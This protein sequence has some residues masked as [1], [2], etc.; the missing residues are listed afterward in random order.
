MKSKLDEMQEKKLAE[1][2]SSAYWIAF[3]GLFAA[4]MIQNFMGN[5]K[6]ALG[7][8][9]VFLVLALYVSVRCIRNGI[10]DRR[11]QANRRTNLIISLI[12]G[13]FVFAFNMLLTMKWHNTAVMLISSVIT[14]VFTFIICFAFLSICMTVYNKRKRELEGEEDET[15]EQ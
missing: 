3:W 13:A 12:G 2:E 6:D 5:V 14:A 15:E 8:L 9:I 10:W 7:E 11:L 4:I 1:I